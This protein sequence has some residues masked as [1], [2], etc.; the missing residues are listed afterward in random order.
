MWTPWLFTLVMLFPVAKTPAKNTA[1]ES[2]D[3]AARK[4][5]PHQFG[6]LSN[7]WVRTHTAAAQRGES[8]RADLKF[9]SQSE[10]IT[11]DFGSELPT[12]REPV[13]LPSGMAWK[14]FHV[15]SQGIRSLSFP[16]VLRRP[17][18]YSKRSKLDDEEIWIFGNSKN[19]H[20]HFAVRSRTSGPT[21][22]SGDGNGKYGTFKVGMP[23]I[24]NAH[25]ISQ[26]SMISQQ[27]LRGRPVEFIESNGVR[28]IEVV[29]ESAD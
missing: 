8:V 2:A 21:V 11:I 19:R 1:S 14:A 12:M 28:V 10:T 6:E 20:M 27:K 4:S 29:R 17:H 9:D 22:S 13:K 16:I 7:Q 23:P 18:H 26:V 24:F 15:S 5:A 25:F 3:R